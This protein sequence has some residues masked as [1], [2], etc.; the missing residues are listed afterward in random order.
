MCVDKISGIVQNFDI[1]CLTDT[2]LN[3]EFFKSDYFPNAYVVYRAD[4][5]DPHYKNIRGRGGSL[6]AVKTCLC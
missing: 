3:Q 2:W 5:P 1:I 4:R 6:I